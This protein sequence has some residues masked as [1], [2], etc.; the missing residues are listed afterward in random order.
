M[1]I[2]AFNSTDQPGQFQIMSLMVT[3]FF[4]QSEESMG[5]SYFFTQI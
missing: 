1:T 5:K 3:M 4:S 2:E